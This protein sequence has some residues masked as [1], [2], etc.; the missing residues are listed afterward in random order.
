MLQLPVSPGHSCPLARTTTLNPD[1]T[2][3][4]IPGGLK[5]DVDNFMTPVSQ[6]LQEQNDTGFGINAWPPAQN[7]CPRPAV[8][9][10]TGAARR[11][12]AHALLPRALLGNGLPDGVS[13]AAGSG[14]CSGARVTV[15]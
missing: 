4:L 12:P 1:S 14:A 10:G 3:A 11:P 8:P 2:T 7:R 5:R 6:N 13:L 9:L 15:F